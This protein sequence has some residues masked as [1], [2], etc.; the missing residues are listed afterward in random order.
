MGWFD[1]QIRTRQKCDD[2]AI[3]DAIASV[4]DA[5]TGG[6]LLQSIGSADA[7]EEKAIGDILSY[8]HIR[9]NASVP[10]GASL[11]ARLEVLMRPYGIMRRSVNLT[12]TW[13]KDAIGV[14]LAKKKDGSLIALIPSGISGYRMFDEKKGKLVKIGKEEAALLANEAVL[15]YRPLPSRAL[16]WQDIIRFLLKSISLSDVLFVLFIMALSAFAGA[17]APVLTQMIYAKAVPTGSYGLLSAIGI[18]LI[19]VTLSSTLFLQLESLFGKRISSKLSL[20]LHAASAMRILSLPVSFFRTWSSGDLSSRLSYF[21]VIAEQLA[22]LVFSGFLRIILSIIFVIQV[23]CIVPSLIWPA[24]LL[25]VLSFLSLVIAIVSK[26][27]LLYRTLQLS[28]SVQGMGYALISGVQKIRLAG[29][30][31]R[32]FARWGRLYAEQAELQ[33]HPPFLLRVYPVLSTAIS[34]FVLW[35]V[36][37]H[38]GKAGVTL[39]SF[40]AFFASFALIQESVNSLLGLS[41][42][43]TALKPEFEM[44]A[45]IIETASEISEKNDVVPKLSGSIELSGVYFRYKNDMPFVV[46]NLSLKIRAGDYVAIVGATGCGKSTLMRLLLGFEKPEK[47]A[48]YY[49]GK[50]MASY[51]MKSLRKHIGVVTQNGKLFSGSI[52]EN[53]AIS[54]PGLSMDDAWAIADSVGLGDDIR[55]MPMNMFTQL[56]DGGGGISGGQRQ[57][58]MIARALA[59]KP[60]VLMFDEAT[61]ALDNI[62]QAQVCA[63][64]D[65]LKCTRIVI[66]HRLST[67][68]NCKRILVLQNGI[69]AEDGS[70]DELVAK[71]GIFAELVKRQMLTTAEK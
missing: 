31:K 34:L 13:Y 39:A 16:K 50:D 5:I 58:L 69:I 6:S 29:A 47:G 27:K 17:F 65:A 54:I 44:I 12:G 53:I 30:E 40:F 42:T 10:A 7:R 37:Y 15:F 38:A 8:F 3:A 51:D 33:Y 45:P 67:I 2:S 9:S 18:A 59:P 66:A 43:M 4:S 24:V 11:D 21:P 20:S 19:A 28:S 60:R 32:A 46:N 70:Y 26:Q 14:M 68:R 63:T 62:T 52:Y 41:D 1:E 36:F 71:D 55:Q 49:D 22:G 56:T 61:S 23:A 57:R 64:I 35:L 48:I 25:V